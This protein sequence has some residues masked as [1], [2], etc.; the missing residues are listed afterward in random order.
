M[1]YI[2][3][4]ITT[5]ILLAQCSSKPPEAAAENASA[6]SATYITV[7]DAQ[8]KAANITFGKIEQKSVAQHLQVS[9]KLDVPP[10]NLVTIAAPMGGFVKNTTLLQGMKVNKGDVLATMENQEYIQLQQ[11]YLDNKSKLEFLEAEYNRQQELARENVNAQKA[12]QQAKSQYTSIKAMVSGLEAK[13]SMINISPASLANGNVRSTINLYAPLSG[14]I[15]EVNVNMGQYVNATDVM[16]RIVNLEHIHAELQV[17]EKD[18]SKIAVGQKVLFQASNE[19]TPREAAVYLI[20][21]EIS[22]ERT[23]RVHCHL[24]IEDPKLLPG[25]FIT[26]TIEISSAPADAAPTSSIVNFEGDNYIFIAAADKNHF[27]AIPVKTGDNAGEFTAI[28]LPENFNR[29]T[30]IVTQGSFELLGL[31]KNQ[32]EEE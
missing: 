2:V 11:D 5:G 13:L 21:K 15:T 8:Y 7:S 27:R 25:M 28:E 22:A 30:P 29:Q 18:I 26:A 16:F 23:V 14:Y 19:T 4:W 6:D 9:G 17:Y 31:L 20:G 10:Q 1:K 32:E 3:I 12:L 24:E